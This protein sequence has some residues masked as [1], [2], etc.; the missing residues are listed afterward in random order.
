M[1]SCQNKLNSKKKNCIFQSR[2]NAALIYIL[3]ER[4][5]KRDAFTCVLETVVFVF[6]DKINK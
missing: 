4:E 5:R 3:R 2:S 1:N 6:V